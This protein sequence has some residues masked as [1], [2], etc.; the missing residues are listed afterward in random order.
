MHCQDGEEKGVRMN[1]MV[2]AKGS[3]Q[4]LTKW[5]R[6]LKEWTLQ[7]SFLVV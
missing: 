4:S 7:A 2:R 1:V 5:G 3:N 6:N